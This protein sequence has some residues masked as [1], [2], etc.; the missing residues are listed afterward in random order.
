MYVREKVLLCA[1]MRLRQHGKSISKTYL[2]KFLFILG[3]ESEIGRVTKFYDFYPHLYGPYSSQFYLDLADLQSR[4]FLDADLTP[5]IPNEKIEEMVDRKISSNIEATIERI[6]DKNIVDYVYSRYPEYTSRSVIIPHKTNDLKPGLFS[7]GYEGHNIDS[8]LNV[9]IQNNIE[10]VADLRYNPFSMNLAFTKSRLAHYLKGVGI[11]YEHIPEL[12][13]DGKY[14]KSLKDDADYTQLFKFYS[15]EILPK[16]QEKVSYLAGRGRKNRVAML[17]FE[18]DKDHCHRG[19][20]SGELEKDS[21]V[22]NH[23]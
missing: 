17:C 18:H 16:Q 12:G 9:L 8:F 5:L 13:I 1:V 21:I 2:D 4:A 11:T 10:A 6:A 7:I 20:V 19:I 23:L 15:E 22:V 14:R 3:K